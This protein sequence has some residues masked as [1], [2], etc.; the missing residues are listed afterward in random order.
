[1]VWWIHYATLPEAATFRIGLCPIQLKWIKSSYPHVHFFGE[2]N[3][4]ER[5]KRKKLQ[6]KLRDAALT[7]LVLSQTQPGEEYA[8]LGFKQFVLSRLNSE[9]ERIVF[10]GTYYYDLSPRDIQAEK[11]DLFPHV[12]DVYR[13]KENILKRLRRDSDFQTRLCNR[14][15]SQDDGEKSAH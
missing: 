13:T 7:E 1:M 5:T 10:E 15:H 8:D 9:E 3:I 6:E 12:R 14:T 11:P 4:R 2:T